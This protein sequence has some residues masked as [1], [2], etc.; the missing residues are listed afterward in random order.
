MGVLAQHPPTISSLSAINS[1]L[2]VS[3]AQTHKA[4]HSL[5]APKTAFL[6]PPAPKFNTTKKQ[7][8]QPIVGMA[9]PRRV[10]MVARQI[11]KEIADMLLRD[12]VLQR[13]VLPE[14]ALGAD[15]YLTSLATI[16]DVEVS[17]DLQVAKVYVSVC[18]DDRGQEIAIKGLKAKHKYVQSQLGKR[19]R[20]RI[21]PEVRF[22]QD[23]SLARGTEII[24]ILNDL[25]RERKIQEEKQQSANNDLDENQML[26]ELPEEDNQTSDEDDEDLIFI[27]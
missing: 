16:S 9:H 19:M 21:T 20:L 13:A 7:G 14:S 18:A 2:T 6:S 23:D 22:I 4:L 11:R 15:M 25:K 12:K 26:Q 27:R 17:K 24:S 10:E 5:N 1:L 8:H 3:T